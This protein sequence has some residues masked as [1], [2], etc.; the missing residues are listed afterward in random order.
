MSEKRKNCLLLAAVILLVA[1]LAVTGIL[2][3]DQQISLTERR[4]LAQ[5]P[6]VSVSSVLD[7]SFSEAFD[8]YSQ[9]Q[10]PFREWF[11]RVRAWTNRLVFRL[12]DDNGIYIEDGYAAKIEYPLDEASVSH[13]AARFS[14]V[15]ERYLAD[16][17]SAV[18]VSVVPDKGYVLAGKHGAPAMDEEKLTDLLAGQMPYASYIDL[19]PVLSLEDY[20]ATDIHWR[21]EKIVP[22]ARVLLQKMKEDSGNPTDPVIPAAMDGGDTKDTALQ[23]ADVPAEDGGYTT[24]KA[25]DAFYG[26]YCGQTALSLAPD[27]L[28]YLDSEWLS[29]CTVWDYEAQKEISVYDLSQAAGRDPYSMFLGGSR[30]LLT[31]TNPAASSDRELLLFRDSFGSSIAPLLAEGYAKITLID[32]RYISPELLDRFVTFDGQDVLFLYSVSVL[33]HSETIR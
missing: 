29:G 1:G 22:A 30:A 24:E 4:S 27:L 18:Y 32:I 9:D 25:S 20:Y 5:L 15:Y 3:P 2:L 23:E 19:F 7:K 17:G 10:F 33:N 21:Q 31:I 13:A 16:A 14:Y 8:S 12:R 11:R 6:T 26:V 28:Y